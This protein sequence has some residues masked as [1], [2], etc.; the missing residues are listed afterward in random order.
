MDRYYYEAVLTPD[1]H[2]GYEVCFPDFDIVTQGSDL[3]DAAVMAQDLLGPY[4]SSLL[5]RGERVDH[6]GR[7]RGT[8]PNG[9]ITMGI[10]TLVDASSADVETMSVEDAADIL[11]VSRSRIYAMIRDGVLGAR[12][13]G[14]MQEVFAQDVMERFNHP[15]S[16]GRP[17]GASLEA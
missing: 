6:A 2:G 17:R 15:R 7:F 13:V 14:R 4:I 3:T 5:E 12:K 9:G 1:G 16:A 8:A 10:M 11:D